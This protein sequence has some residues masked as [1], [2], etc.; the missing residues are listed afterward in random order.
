MNVEYV[1]Q[2]AERI[3]GPTYEAA[4]EI[5][6]QAGRICYRSESKGDPEGFARGLIK[7]GHESVIEHVSATYKICTDRA[8]QN[9]IVRHRIASYSVESSIHTDYNSDRMH[10]TICVIPPLGLDTDSEF[11]FRYAVLS[12]ANKYEV[13]REQHVS[14][15]A[16]RSVLPLC[17]ATNMVMT[18]NF[19]EWR[20]FIKLRTSKHAHPLMQELARMIRDDLAATYPVF[21]EDLIHDE[22]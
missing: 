3:A 16:A 19:R 8:I 17:L 12:A 1:K 11:T 9:Q 18:A 20:H 15:N 6:E 5:V 22:N 21:F 14:L 7:R 13:L 2:T 4:L 10:G